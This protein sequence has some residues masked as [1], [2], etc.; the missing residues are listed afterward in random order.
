M[1]DHSLVPMAAKA[2]GIGFGDL[3]KQILSLAIEK[4]TGEQAR[5]E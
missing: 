5:V 2:A 3:V 4:N 1:T